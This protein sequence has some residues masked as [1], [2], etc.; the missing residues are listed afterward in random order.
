MIVDMLALSN[1]EL[2]LFQI[3]S[4][5]NNISFKL[6][7]IYPWMDYTNLLISNDNYEQNVR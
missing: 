7:L 1:V 6:F 4:Q 3:S 5:R 2:V